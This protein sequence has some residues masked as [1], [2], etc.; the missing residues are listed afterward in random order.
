MNPAIPLLQ[1]LIEIPSVSAMSNRPLIDRVSKL[2]HQ[3]GWHTLAIPYHD[4]FGTE[5]V[6]LIAAP[7]GQNPA[8]RTVDLAFVCHTDTVPF[9]PEWKDATRPYVRDGFVYGCGACDVKGFLAC[10]L[11]TL[12]DLQPVN[13]RRTVRIVLTA[14]EEVGCVGASKLIASKAIHPKQAVIGEPTSLRAARAGKGYWLA[15]VKVFGKEAHSAH[16]SEGASAIYRAAHLITKIEE[17]SSRLREDRR[18]G[19]EPPFS[20]LNVG[21]I[22]GGTAKNIVPGECKFLLEWRPI[23]EQDIRLIHGALN[24]AAEEL[25][26]TDPNFKHEMKILRDQPGFD[27]GTNSFMVRSFERITRKPSITIPFGTEAS[28][29]SQVAEDVVVFGPGDMRTAHSS[30]ERV[31]TDEL[32]ECM[33]VLKELMTTMAAN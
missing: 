12:P 1:A 2:F 31:S 3:S 25:R 27:A 7:P 4:E 10:L 5:K 22:E 17:I 8:D 18:D 13:F 19:F 16:P 32:E 15:E 9:D 20:T 6:N 11:A 24:S 30:R 33:E 14:D 26:S 29:L 21:K 23:P 28:V